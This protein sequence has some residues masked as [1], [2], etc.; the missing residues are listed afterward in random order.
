MC[1]LSIFF[2]VLNFFLSCKIWFTVLSFVC[3]LKFCIVEFCSRSEFCLFKNLLSPISVLSKMMCFCIDFLIP[4]GLTSGVTVKF[5]WVIVKI[6]L[7]MKENK[8]EKSL[9][10]L[11]H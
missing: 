2:I 3:C 6:G 7:S 9:N 1:S 4:S 8:L 11:G 10:S 5:L